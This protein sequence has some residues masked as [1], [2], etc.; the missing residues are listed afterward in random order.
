MKFQSMKIRIPGAAL[1]FLLLAA[2]PVAA[3]SFSADRYY[4]QC[5]RFEAGGDLESARESCRN[6]LEVAPERMDALLVIARIDVELDELSQAETALLKV[7]NK[8]ATA[9]PLV[10]LAE[11]MLRQQRLAEAEGYLVAAEQRLLSNHSSALAA[12]TAFLTG[13]LLLQRGEFQAALAEYRQAATS[14]PLVSR[15]YVAAARVLLALGLPEAAAA[16]LEGFRTTTGEQGDAELHALLGRAEWAAGRLPAA[17]SELETA[18]LLRGGRNAAAQAADLRNLAAIYFGQGDVTRGSLALQDA[19]RQGNL[20][21]LLAGNPLL[22]LLLLL[23]IAGAHLVGESRVPATAATIPAGPQLWR[24]RQVYG[25][26]LGAAGLG[27][28]AAFAYGAV[29]HDN[30][31]AFVTPLQSQEAR[32]AFLIVFT[33]VAAGSAWLRVRRSGFSP[34]ETL[35]GR[36]DHLL[37]G[38][39]VGVLLTGVALLYLGLQPRFGLVGSFYFNLNQLTPL[40]LVALIVLPFSELFFRAFALPPF[41]QRYG[42]AFAA[43]LSAGLYALVLG[44]PVLLLLVLGGIVAVAFERTGSGL[45]VFVAQL[46]LHAGLLLAVT[47]NSW[48]SALF[49]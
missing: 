24:V 11:I 5:L 48:A 1:L 39:G 41:S 21:E 14:E 18:F 30:Y 42:T 12:R 43:L 19:L 3:Q 38:I 4:E 22:W 31:L 37:A 36:S 44:T 29:V 34:L 20:L 45:L 49:L 9:E 17:A 28:I 46:T 15:Y 2:G 27:L 16:E 8:L 13:E 26:L 35:L 32:A 10:L 7:R 6:A 40:V 47:L 33:L 23:V 25:V